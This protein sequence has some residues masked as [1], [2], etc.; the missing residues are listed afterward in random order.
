M[1]L[2]S[3]TLSTPTLRG[4]TSPVYGTSVA[5]EAELQRSEEPWKSERVICQKIYID[6]SLFRCNSFIFSLFEG[7]PDFIGPALVLY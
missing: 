5:L 6:F 1:L 2:S 4:R 7:V 3:K